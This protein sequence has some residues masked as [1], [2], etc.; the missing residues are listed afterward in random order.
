[1]KLSLIGCGT[2]NLDH[3][4]IQGI[5]ALGCADLILLP[6][7]G[8]AKS[9]LADVRRNMLSM[10]LP[11]DKHPRI[12]PITFPTRRTDIAY[13]DAV[14]QWHVE[15]AELW[16]EAINITPKPQHTA[17]LIW[18]D[19]SLYDSAL[20]IAERLEPKPVLNVI[21]GITSI[22][23]LTA[24]HQITLNQ[25]A[26][27]VKI[28]TGRNLRENGF[29]E[30]VN[31]IVVMLDGNSAFQTLSQEDYYIY[32]GAYLGMDEEILC[33]GKLS[34]VATKIIDMRASARTTHGWIMDCYLIRKLARD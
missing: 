3:I 29:P 34:D 32:W 27:D 15:I 6:E 22:Q 26:D 23:V 25:L 5:K 1:M 16:Q 8:E 11:A 2:G 12:A 20:R 7:K 14:I 4:T 28:M 13:R 31:T 30:D 17:L 9:A 24:A 10:H 18:G 19:P 21:P 33:A